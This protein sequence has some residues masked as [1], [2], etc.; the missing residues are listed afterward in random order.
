MEVSLIKWRKREITTAICSIVLVVLNVCVFH[1]VWNRFYA[2]NYYSHFYSVGRYAPSAVCLV[3]YAFLGRLYGTF[4]L[5]I[6][7]ITEILYANVVTNLITGGILYIIAW[8]LIRHL[9]NIGPM[10]LII[11]IWTMMACLWIKPSIL[12]INHY[13]YIERMAIIYGSCEN[14]HNGKAIMERVKWRFRFAGEI[15]AEEDLE[16]IKVKLEVYHAEAV[17]I[18]NIPI[19]VR[20]EILRYCI[21]QNIVTY[22][23]PGVGDYLIN[24]SR[25]VQLGNMPILC[26]QRTSSMNLYTFMKRIFDILLSAVGIIAASPLMLGIAAAIKLFDHGP[27]FVKEKRLT[28]NKRTFEM[29][30]FRTTRLNQNEEN[31]KLYSIYDERLIPVG[32]FLSRY[33]LDGLPRL[34]DV[35]RGEIS[36]VGPRAEKIDEAEAYEQ[37]MPEYGLKFQVKAGLT[38]HVQIFGRYYT[39]VDDRL[40]MDLRYLSQ[41][42]LASDLKLLLATIKVIFLPEG[43][44]LIL[45]GRVFTEEKDCGK[46]KA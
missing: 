42:S 12:F 21:S 38:G 8:I 28:I 35:L 30:K 4:W 7:R 23:Q 6:S 44:D 26:C 3:L 5:R 19:D 2:P 11:G 25:A 14:F 33:R 40:Q 1:L 24:S 29:H 32:K 36:L 39:S 31:R 41:Q 22:I 13:C 15:S 10:L 43:M 46:I 37:Q 17:L 45:D 16:I 20:N 27:V 9:P 34:F 18:C